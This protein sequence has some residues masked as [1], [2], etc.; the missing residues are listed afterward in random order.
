MG[1][2]PAIA[3]AAY[4]VAQS[5]GHVYVHVTDAKSGKP[6]P[7]WTVQVT[8]RDGDVQQITDRNGAA[9]FL[10]VSIGIAR[11][12]VLRS[13]K[14]A[15]CPAVVDV[16]PDESTVVNVHVRDGGRISNCNP[17]R[18]EV[19]VRPGVTSDVYDVF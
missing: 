8:T 10:I 12:D 2:V 19:H 17:S 5:T 9:T 14:L 13:G 3:A 15:V 16:S 11:I 6:F 1:L 18:A 7:G 4:L